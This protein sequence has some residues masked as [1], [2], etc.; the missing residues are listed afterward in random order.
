M[1]IGGG[2][3]GAHDRLGFAG[4]EQHVLAAQADER[5]VAVDEAASRRAAHEPQEVVGDDVG[6]AHG[7]DLV[8]AGEVDTV[9]AG[10]GD[11][12][13]REGRGGVEQFAQEIALQLPLDLLLCALLDELQREHGGRVLERLG[14]QRGELVETAHVDATEILDGKPIVPSGPSGTRRAVARAKRR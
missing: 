5:G 10:A 9:P 13:R 1:A 12:R 8:R 14:L 7:D 2:G 3:D 4:R 6:A 11:Q